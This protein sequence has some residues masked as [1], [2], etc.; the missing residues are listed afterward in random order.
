MPN[1]QI[2]TYT[3]DP[4]IGVRSITPPSGIR[5]VY[6]YDSANRLKEIRENNQ[7]GN[8]LKEFKYNYKQ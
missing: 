4:L 1:Y 3:Y 2:T 5:E 6:I 8:L 7:T